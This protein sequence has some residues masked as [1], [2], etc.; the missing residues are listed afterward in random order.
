MDLNCLNYQEIRAV[1]LSSVPHR[2]SSQ[3]IN[4]IECLNSYC[5]NIHVSSFFNL[6]YI[7]FIFLLVNYTKNR[8]KL[9]ARNKPNTSRARSVSQA[10][11]I[12]IEL[13]ER[14]RIEIAK[15]L[16]NRSYL[17]I[18][19]DLLIVT[20]L[21]LSLVSVIESLQTIRAG[22]SDFLYGRL[23]H[24]TSVIFVLLFHYFKIVPDIRMFRIRFKACPSL[25][26]VFHGMVTLFWLIS[27]GSL[28]YQLVLLHQLG[29]QVHIHVRFQITLLM[30][31][32]TLATLGCILIATSGTLVSTVHENC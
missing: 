6:F 28:M 20:Q 21:L 1:F 12:T 11:D 9:A 29:L 18:A 30:A 22:I 13:E 8:R 27:A 16:W 7:L 32:C 3:L 31:L 17:K 25:P 23:L 5:S 2:N 19:M 10:N 24:K 4:T 26:K 14:D 15:K